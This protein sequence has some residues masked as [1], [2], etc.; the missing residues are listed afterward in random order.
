MGAEFWLLMKSPPEAKRVMNTL[1]FLTGKLQLA[2]GP[3]CEITRPSPKQITLTHNYDW[4]SRVLADIVA[5]E[6]AKVFDVRKIGADSVGWFPDKSW[7]SDDPK[8]AKA[9][10]GNYK[11][12]AAWL[13]DYKLEWA[14]PTEAKMR[15]VLPN[16]L[17]PQAEEIE[18]RV[19]FVL[20]SPPAVP[21]RV[22]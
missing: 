16:D 5:R 10:Y 8:G 21:A 2:D 11:T 18:R 4:P 15:G 22:E 14:L 17:L 6:I 3:E 20:R 1:S 7:L 19:M 9:T 12:W 13:K